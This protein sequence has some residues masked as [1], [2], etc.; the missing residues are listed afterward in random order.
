MA[1]ILRATDSGDNEVGDHLVGN[2]PHLLGIMS[3]SGLCQ[4]QHYVAFGVMSCG[5]MLHSDL[6]RSV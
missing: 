5:I 1:N 2:G 4:I 3:H 6:C